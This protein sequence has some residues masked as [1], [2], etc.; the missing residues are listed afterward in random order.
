MKACTAGTALCVWGGSVQR[1]RLLN[2]TRLN[3]P[4]STVPIRQQSSCM[5]SWGW[6]RGRALHLLTQRL[7][8][9]LPSLHTLLHCSPR[10]L[11]SAPVLPSHHTLPPLSLLL[12]PRPPT[13]P[14]ARPA[15]ACPPPAAPRRT[16]GTRPRRAWGRPSCEQAALGDAAATNALT[17][18]ACPASCASTHSATVVLKHTKQKYT[19]E[20]QRWQGGQGRAGASQPR[21]PTAELSSSRWPPA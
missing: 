14:Q 18:S 5:K 16:G 2:W 10:L 9:Q 20:T 21:I 1:C 17:L 13:A 6:M 3:C 8:H 12:P 15:P 7:A 19:C 11:A 4:Y